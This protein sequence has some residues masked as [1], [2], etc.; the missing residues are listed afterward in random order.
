MLPQEVET[1]NIITS[2][3]Q[4]GMLQLLKKLPQDQ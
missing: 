2:E 3:P 1:P 4:Q